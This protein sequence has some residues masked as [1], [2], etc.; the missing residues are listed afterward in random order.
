VRALGVTDNIAM[1]EGD[2]TDGIDHYKKS[3]RQGR[4]TP[5]NR[6]PPLTCSVSAGRRG[7]RPEVG[8]FCLPHAHQGETPEEMAGF[9]DAVSSRLATF[10][11]TG[12]TP[13]V[14]LPS[15]NGARKRC[16]LTS[17]LG[18]Y[19]EGVGVDWIWRTPTRSSRVFVSEVLQ[20]LDLIAM[21]AIDSIAPGQWPLPDGLPARRSA[22]ARRAPIL[23]GSV[24]AQPGQTHEPVRWTPAW[25][26]QPHPPR[27]RGVHQTF[28]AGPPT[29]CCCA[30]P[31]GEWWPTRRM[32][33]WTPS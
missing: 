23:V 29:R 32:P 5:L 31:K 10:Q 4:R 16:S 25:W 27:V 13:T 17:L 1:N 33:G 26:S 8:A 21:P 30:A 6:E 7:E 20:A 24:D 28:E 18:L 14:V 15:H 11:S 12:H 2:H 3:T 9:L 19:C 22:P